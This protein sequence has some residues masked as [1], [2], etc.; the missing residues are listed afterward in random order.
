MNELQLILGL[1]IVFLPFVF[2]LRFLYH[3]DIKRKWLILIMGAMFWFFALLA[4]LI[5]LG[6]VQVFE[7]IRAGFDITK[8]PTQSELD[9]MNMFLNNDPVYLASAPI[10]AGIFEETFRYILFKLMPSSRERSLSA[11]TVGVGWTLGEIFVLYVLSMIPILFISTE[12][13]YLNVVLGGIERWSASIIHISLTFLVFWSLSEKFPKVS[14]LLAITLHTIFDLIAVFGAKFLVA[15]FGSIAGI[16][17]LEAIIFVSAVL[18]ALYV[19]KQIQKRGY[20]LNLLSTI[21]I[22]IKGIEN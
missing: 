2:I 21:K 19:F 3:R 11:F 8:V 22:L 4:R 15:I 1:T 12:I 13:S 16:I 9:A 5:P 18:V 10:L 7:L 14:L 20:P 17:L 6:L